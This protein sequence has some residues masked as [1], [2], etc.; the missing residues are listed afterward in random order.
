MKPNKVGFADGVRY[1]LALL[2]ETA[3][4][5]I[6]EILGAGGSST[7]VPVAYSAAKIEL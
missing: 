1:N 3:A 2:N 7:D 4:D 6:L 5:E